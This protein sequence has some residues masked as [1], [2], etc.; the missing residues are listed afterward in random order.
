MPAPRCTKDSALLCSRRWLAAHPWFAP[1]KLRCR[2]WQERL[3]SM[4]I[5]VVRKSLLALFCMCS[6]LRNCGRSGLK[7]VTK[8]CRGSVGTKLQLRHLPCMNR[9]A[10]RLPGKWHTL[11]SHYAKPEDRGKRPSSCECNHRLRHLVSWRICA[12]PGCPCVCQ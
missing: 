12:Q 9:Q 10:E 4:P 5:P 2:K 6:L 7:E 11:E 8:I 1:V 3:R